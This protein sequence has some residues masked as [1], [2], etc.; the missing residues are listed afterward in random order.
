[1]RFDTV[2][3]DSGGA[4][5]PPRS[6]VSVIRFRYTGE[7][8]K[9]EDRFVNP[10]G[11]QVLRYRRDAEAPPAEAVPAATTALPGQPV[12]VGVPTPVAVGAAPGGATT[13]TTTTTVAPAAGTPLGSAA[14]AAQRAA[15][16]RAAE[17]RNRA[18]EPEL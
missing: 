10:L 16:A 8:M 2:R 18:P 6:W 17:R 11:F 12:V 5:H 13:T 15:A 4:L 1:V 9:L 7:S 3:Q 14:T